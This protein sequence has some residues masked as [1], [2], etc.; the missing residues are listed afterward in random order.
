MIIIWAFVNRQG[1]DEI[2]K[3]PACGA[4]FIKTDIFMLSAWKNTDG[5][6]GFSLAAEFDDAIDE[7]KESK[8]STHT[9][10]LTR[11]YSGAALAYDNRSGGYGLT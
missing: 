6:S 10:I 4:F 8:I 9:H 11:I 2:K 5:L 7:R 3:Y 1:E